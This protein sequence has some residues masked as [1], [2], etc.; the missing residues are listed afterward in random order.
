ML[1]VYVAT[2]LQL[3]TLNDMQELRFNSNISTKTLLR[4]PYDLLLEYVHRGDAIPIDATAKDA[5]KHEHVY[6][7]QHAYMTH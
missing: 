7:I 4:I 6:A 1:H 5:Q 2:I 3:P